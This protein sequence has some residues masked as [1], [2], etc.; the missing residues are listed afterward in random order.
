MSQ[1]KYPVHRNESHVPK[2]HH[3][4]KTTTKASVHSS[5]LQVHNAES[6][7]ILWLRRLML[8]RVH[9]T[10]ILVERPE[11]VPEKTRWVVL[12]LERDEAF[13]V[14]AEGSGHARGDLMSSKEL[15][16]APLYMRTPSFTPCH[17]EKRA[18]RWK[19]ATTYHRL[20]RV[21]K[22]LFYGEGKGRKII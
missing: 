10:T 16:I 11:R 8:A 15:R 2:I 17:H 21:S 12:L 4:T 14:L 5:Y 1:K 13:P 9:L 20:H 22:P 18:Y 19:G 6:V 3:R 7:L